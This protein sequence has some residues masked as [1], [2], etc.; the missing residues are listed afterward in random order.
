VPTGAAEA[1]ELALPAEPAWVPTPAQRRIEPLLAALAAEPEPEP[2]AGFFA[3]LA[4]WFA[5]CARFG[6]RR[7]P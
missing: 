1:A 2:A 4:R 7:R 6:L 5:G 3:R